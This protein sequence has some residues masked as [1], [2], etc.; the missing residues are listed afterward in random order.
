MMGFDKHRLFF[1]FPVIGINSRALHML[2][3]SIISKCTSVIG[4]LRDY[5]HYLFRT[6]P[7]HFSK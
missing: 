7:F 4:V 6:F 3:K 2:V 5:H 1:F